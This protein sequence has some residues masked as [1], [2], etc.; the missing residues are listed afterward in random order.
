MKQ[1][2][3]GILA[4]FVRNP[5]FANLLAIGTMVGGLVA[6]YKLPRETFPETATDHVLITVPYPGASAEDVERGV[7]IK[8]E[9]AVQGVAGLGEVSSLSSEDAS[10][11]LA[12]FDPAVITPT[13]VLRQIQDRVNSIRTFPPDAERPLINEAVV[14][15][16]VVS[17]G[18]SGDV[19][20]AA[21]KRVAE[22]IRDELAL[23]SEIS[24]IN[25]SGV[26]DYQISIQLTEETLQRFGLTMREVINRV[27]ASSL[28]LPAGTVRT[29]NEEINVRT[30]GQRYTTHDFAD[31]VVIARP[32]GSTVQLGQIAVIRDTFEDTPLYGRV[33]GQP[34]ATVTVSKTGTED[35]SSIARIVRE[36]VD[37]VRPR[38]PEGIHLTVLADKS[39]DVDGRLNMLISNALQGMALLMICLM[40]FMDFRAALGVAMGIPVATAGALWVLHMTGSTLNMISL[41]GL[42]LADAIVLDDSIVIAESIIAAEKDGLTPDLAAIRA[43]RRVAGPVLTSSITTIVMFVPLMY[44]QGVM[45]KLIYVLPVAVLATIVASAMEAFLILPAHMA[46]WAHRGREGR[47]NAW[48]VRVRRRLNSGIEIT[49]ARLY[50][51]IITRLAR[52]RWVVLGGTAGFVL[53]CLGVVLGGRTPFVLFPKLDANTLRA[54]VR[55]PEGTP[56]DLAQAAVDRIEQ[57]ARDLN[58][59]PTLAPAAEGKLVQHIYSTVGEWSDFVSKRGSG[60]GQTTIELMP[61]EERRRDCN[62][63]IAHWR[64]AIGTVPGAELL[65]IEREE[66]GPN[67]K[68][69]EI[70][71]LGN[72]LEEMRRAAD[73]VREK[74]AEFEGVFDID[75]DLRPGKRE[76]RVVLKPEAANLGLTVAGVAE[77]LRQGLYGGEAVRLQRG[78]DDVRVL[79]SYVDADRRDWSIIDDLKIR[80]PAGGAV[81]F[82]EVAE[83][84]LIRGYSEIVR[85]DGMRRVR[86][87]ADVDEHHAN[88][89]RIIATMLASFLPDLDARYTGVSYR[90]DGQRARI[91]Q[92]LTSL[93]MA[94]LVA[95]AISYA[96]LGAATRSYLQPLILIAAVP[97]GLCGA[98]LGHTIMGFDLSLMS[99]FGMTSLAGIVVNDGLVL[100]DQL[101]HNVKNGMGIQEAVAKAARARVL[102]VFLTALTNAA[103]LLPLLT[104]RST[105]ALPLIPIAISV[106][107]GLTF[108]TVLVLLIVPS[109]YLVFNDAKRLARWLRHGGA[110]PRPEEVER[111]EDAHVVVPA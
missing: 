20:E 43:T 78:R 74:L 39:R 77:Q 92:S 10:K 38:M 60:L 42:L 75:D 52:F 24:Q 13:E 91:D 87:Q 72:N 103:G 36:F 108:S 47:F 2:D 23:R 85:Q 90:I 11:V 41:F 61:A 93:A 3:E 25:L 14:R 99:V 96:I 83:T 16:P 35:I 27:S 105:Q 31:L 32:D 49:V 107:F 12:Q 55:F 40:L 44:V 65:S 95:F 6:A 26:R 94:S 80:T 110:Y 101:N 9:E 70:R 73:E 29:R 63:I 71:L 48:R 97:L 81:P 82:H 4:A 1:P 22:Q 76:L 79:V 62:V 86:V 100:L 106:V 15:V 54:R 30:M 59:D 7:T 21:I 45:G 46:H 64:E 5:V 53:V 66:L 69:L 56:V 111:T 58:D 84:R 98:V 109:L 17:I 8:I 18:V 68:P 89:E 19:S 37:Q 67:E 102:A 50:S 51:P 104:A 28:D 33:N 34:G 57:A 88:A